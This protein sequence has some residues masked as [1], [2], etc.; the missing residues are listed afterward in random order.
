LADVPLA[1]TCA[2]G[3]SVNH[4]PAGSV[5]AASRTGSRSGQFEAS[6]FL[7]CKR[8]G[9]IRAAFETHWQIPLDRAG[10][11]AHSV[12]LETDENP[13]RPGTPDAKRNLTPDP[14]KK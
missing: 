14:A 2:C 11:V 8:C 12:A 10:D 1:D 9:A 7:W 5:E 4:R 6:R 13:T 3:S